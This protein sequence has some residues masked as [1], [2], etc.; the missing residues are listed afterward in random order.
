MICF[1]RSDL[2]IE[3]P[4]ES[5]ETRTNY[6]KLITVQ[7]GKIICYDGG[8]YNLSELCYDYDNTNITRHLTQSNP[9]M[10]AVC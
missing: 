3:R 9:L 1:S 2:K 8:E 5:K 6:N 10:G 4:D 7:T